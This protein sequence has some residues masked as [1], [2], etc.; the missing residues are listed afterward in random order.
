MKVIVGVKMSLLPIIT[1]FF[2]GFVTWSLAI[3]RLITLEGRRLVLLCG[4]V[5]VDEV[6]A[7]ELGIYLARNGSH[8]E[9][10]ACAMGGTLAAYIMVRIA[11]R[12]K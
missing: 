5:F 12:H 8:L 2:V 4:L 6:I 10:V 11:D 1:M 7:L 9:A 3:Y